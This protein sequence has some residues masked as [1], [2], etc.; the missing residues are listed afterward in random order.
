MANFRT[1]FRA[2]TVLLGLLLAYAGCTTEEFA[3][4][5]ARRS[6]PRFVKMETQ[7]EYSEHEPYA[8]Q[9]E[10]SI[11]GHGLLHQK[12]VGDVTCAKNRVL[13][14][15][16]TSYFREMIDHLVAGSEPDPPKIPQPSLKNMIRT[17][18]CDAQGGFSFAKLPDGAWFVLTQVKTKPVNVLIREV[19]VSNH[20]MIEV[21]LGEKDIVGH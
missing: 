11:R 9:G 5:A 17:T 21:M 2:V 20:R 15:P 4:E 13:L 16:G 7:F 19:T 14:L 3:R 12:V 1:T 6:A 10:N 8:Q 18:E